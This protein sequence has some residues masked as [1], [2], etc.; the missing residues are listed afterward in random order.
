PDSLKNKR[1]IALDIGAMVAGSKYRGEFEER[2]KAVLRELAESEGEVV[3]FIDEL[4]TIVGAGAAEGAID[5]GN[6]LKP[7][8]AR[9]ELRAIGATTLDEHRQHIE[10]DPALE[11]R[12]QPVLVEPPSVEDTI[13]ILRDLQERTAGMKAHWQQERN[14]IDVIRALK[15]EIE[16]V[17]EQAALAERD[18][19][20]ERAAEL[21]Y[22][23]L[24]D[25]ERRLEE[26]NEKL[27]KVQT[28]RKM[29]KE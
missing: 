13:A 16:E 18:A 4:H 28:D 17:R 5:A 11:R 22:G 21:R 20:L 10:K 29:L 12:F 1:V 19:D 26:E 8:L 14:H 2:F 15:S 9:G 24:V 3:T 27:A 7:M 25:L 6:M 23:R